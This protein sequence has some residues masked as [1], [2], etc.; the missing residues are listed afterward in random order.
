M[1]FTEEQKAFRRRKFR[2][3]FARLDVDNDGHITTEDF[4][5]MA[6]RFIAQGKLDEEKGKELTKRL[7][8]VCGLLGMKDGDKMTLEQYLVAAEKYC[9][10]PAGT[11]VTKKPMSLKFDVVD[12]DGDGVISPEEFRMYFKAMGIKESCAKA[13][14]DAIDTDHD[15]S[16]SKKEFLAAVHEFVFGADPTSGGT[17]FFGPLVE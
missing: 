11:Q 3:C 12:T 9:E 5:E 6:R 4:R 17:L 1:S 13:S 15:G 8:D 7:L 16:I 14:F 2:T 10:D